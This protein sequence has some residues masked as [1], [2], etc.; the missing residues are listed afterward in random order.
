MP[1]TVFYSL[2][3]GKQKKRNNKGYKRVS[4]EKTRTLQ[5]PT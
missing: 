1:L 4:V 2:G 3:C 5:Q